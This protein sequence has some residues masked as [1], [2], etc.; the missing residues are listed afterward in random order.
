MEK[1]ILNTKIQDLSDKSIARAFKNCFGSMTLDEY[2]KFLENHPNKITTQESHFYHF[3]LADLWE[4]QKP[5][6]PASIPT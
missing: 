3:L 5:K 1:G 4:L 2:A 6:E